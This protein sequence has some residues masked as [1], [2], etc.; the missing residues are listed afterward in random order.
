MSL[1]I[2]IFKIFSATTYCLYI[3]S[4]KSTYLSTYTSDNPIPSCKNSY[5]L[6]PYYIIGFVDGE[7]CFTTYIFKDSRMSTGWQVKPIFKITLQNK[8]RKILEGIQRTFSVG[9][10]YKQGEYAMRIVLVL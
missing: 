3:N 4:I 6:N 7:G 2:Y 8:D 1:L 10:I 5:Y 9:K